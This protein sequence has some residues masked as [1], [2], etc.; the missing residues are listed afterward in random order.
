MLSS[1][2]TRNI[3]FHAKIY[4]IKKVTSSIVDYFNQK[5]FVNFYDFVN[6]NV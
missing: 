4:N 3:Y 2:R 1:I 6:L 5:N